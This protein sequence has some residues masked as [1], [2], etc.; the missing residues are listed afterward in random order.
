[1]VN[2]LIIFSFNLN[3]KCVFILVCK[4]F[5]KRRDLHIILC[6]IICCFISVIYLSLFTAF[7]YLVLILEDNAFICYLKECGQLSHA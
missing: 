1:M 5:W 4:C 2:F 3:E 7:N 6:F